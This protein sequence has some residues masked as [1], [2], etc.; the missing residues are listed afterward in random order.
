M[1]M[2]QS[3][4]AMLG[5]KPNTG[6]VVTGVRDGTPAE[7]AGLKEYDVITAVNG[8]TVTSTIELRNKV[9]MIKPGTKTNFA[10]LREGKEMNFTVTLAELDENL[11]TGAPS[12]EKKVDKTGLTLQNLT[13]E[14]RRQAGLDDSQKGVII[15]DV[16]PSSTAAISR[17]RQSDII[18]EANRK[19]VNSVS[20][21]NR[22][23][24]GVSGDT[25]LLRVQRGGGT[26]FATL[27][28]S[29][30]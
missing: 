23:I 10:V 14:N 4:S 6:V 20:E 19:E 28:L 25:I 21:F 22:I 2:A 9:A 13:P 27:K 8:Q 17:L 30:K 18:L 15:V 16:D 11:L 1:M 5:V 3:L 24:S 26:F 7:K 12:A 29:A